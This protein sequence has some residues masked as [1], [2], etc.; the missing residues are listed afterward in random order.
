MEME[1]YYFTQSLNIAAYLISKG[2]EVK[3]LE[4]S[5]TGITTFFF[6][7]SDGTFEAVKEYNNNDELKKFISA[8]REIKQMVKH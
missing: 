6:E 2:Y 4:N 8:F 3:K 1:N 5:S 7:R